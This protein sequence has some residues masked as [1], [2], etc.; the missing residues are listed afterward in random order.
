MNTLIHYSVMYLEVLGVFVSS[1]FLVC[2]VSWRMLYGRENENLLTH[3]IQQRKPAKKSIQRE[4]RWSVISMFVQA[5]MTVILLICIG[6]GYTK[7]YFHFNEHSLVYFFVSILLAFVIHDAYFYWM[8]RFMHLKA[9]F[10]IVHKIHHLSKTPSPWA[11]YAFHP[12]ENII[13]YSIFPILVFF[14]PLHPYALAFVIIYNMIMNLGGHFGFEFMPAKYFNTWLFKYG[15]TTT[16]HDMHHAKVNCNYGLYF[17]IWDRLM[18]T[19]H[20]EY[21]KTF[22]KVQ[23]QINKKRLPEVVKN[24]Q[25][26]VVPKFMSKD[27]DGLY[28][29]LC[30]RIE[31][32]F[33][34]KGC[35]RKGGNEIPIKIAMICILYS[36]SYGL[37]LSNHFSHGATLLFAVIFGLTNVLIVFN[38]AHDAAHQAL[39][40]S[41]RANNIFSYGF[42]LV[43]TNGY[44]WGITHNQI[45][46]SFPNVADYDLDIHQQSP[47]I[48]ISPTVPRKKYHRFQPYYAVFLYIVTSLFFI[49]KKDFQEFDLLAKKDSKLLLNRKHKPLQY[50]IFFLSK[51]IYWSV[52]ILIPFLV[53]DVHWWQFLMGFLIVHFCMGLVLA[54]V[55]IPVHMVDEAPFAVE[56]DN[57]IEDSWV[58][59][60][61]KNTIDYSRNSKLANFLFGGLNTHLVHHL[62]PG[63]CH[64]HYID[65]S[66]ILKQTVSEFGYEYRSVSMAEAIAS[67][68][69]L[70]KRMS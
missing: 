48:R 34:K 17:N 57:R 20:P 54:T 12:V 23:E 61:L 58:L 65:L 46:H 69:R 29:E 11:I 43:G 44:L 4:I 10:P 37:M 53:I 52:T 49:F 19:N 9:I 66:E 63:I 3:K 40:K 42:N 70:L 36:G 51:A 18:Q 55:L 8:H 6:K 26:V 28:K 64:V 47:L 30:F 7:L 50:V 16:H 27:T 35:S 62:F 22:M 32:Y 25:L 67:H 31:G 33:Q 1:Y 24:Q 68:F 2:G 59:H 5:F 21:E 45:H 14:I 60:V 39:F 15:L 56:V 13:D 41:N 38:I